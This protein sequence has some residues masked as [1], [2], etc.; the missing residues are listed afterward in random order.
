MA[1]AA[2][3]D[4]L[5]FTAEGEIPGIV[6]G[7]RA[8]YRSGKS[9]PLAWRKQQLAAIRRLAGS[10]CVA[11]QSLWCDCGTRAAFARDPQLLVYSGARAAAKR[12]RRAD[13]VRRT[14]MRLRRRLWRICTGRG[15][16]SPRAG[17]G[18][19][20]PRAGRGV[21][22]PRA[23]RGVLSSRAGRGVL[24]PRAGL[25]PRAECD[26]SWVMRIQICVR[27]LSPRACGM[28]RS[29]LRVRVRRLECIVGEVSTVLGEVS[30]AHMHFPY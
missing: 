19:L 20:S 9:R 21:L 16:L 23:G 2:S 25:V 11:L 4:A 7:V 26:H 6:A 8:A 30:Y 5:R 3:V 15:V 14:R 12:S 28:P 22:S 24:S 13:C 18:V 10:A 1:R 27:F 17:R 29:L